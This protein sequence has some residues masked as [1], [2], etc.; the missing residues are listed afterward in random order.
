MTAQQIIDIAAADI[1]Y[2][3]SPKN[4]NKTKFGKWYGMD[5]QPWCMMA[6]Q[7]WYNAAGYTLPYKTASCSALLSWYRKNAPDKIVS[8][9]KANDIIIYDFGHTGILESDNGD[10][11][12]AIEGNTSST[13]AGSQDNGGGVYRRTRSK[14][15]V[16]A[17]IRP[18]DFTEDEMTQEQFNEMFK[19]AM[20]NYQASLRDNDAGSWSKEYREWAIANGLFEGNGTTVDGEPNYMWASPLTREQAAKLFNMFYEMIKK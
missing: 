14:S 15:K 11:I 18:F 9:P 5:G 10:T 16:T 8:N 20:S 2:T 7:Y 13:D 17:Y 4:S 3:E 12:T 19:T 6:V 1:G